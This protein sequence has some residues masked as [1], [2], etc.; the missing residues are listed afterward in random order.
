MPTEY[1]II[2]LFAGP[3][4]LAEGF[5]SI[6]KEDGSQPF[7][8]ALSVEKEASAFDTLR[9]RSFVRQFNGTPPDAYYNFL[10][11]D[12]PEPDWE[13][14]FPIE[15]KSACLETVRLEL[16]S[17]DAT[18]EIDT[19]LAQISQSHGANVILIGGPPCQAYSTSSKQGYQGLRGG[20]GRPPLSIQ[21]IH[22]DSSEGDA[23]C[24]CNGERQ[25]FA[26]VLR[27]WPTRIQSSA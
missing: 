13:E 2:D 4:G 12:I 10:N 5:S 26:L 1:A 24:L 3:G 8:I 7:Q 18:K 15:W 11:G 14:L 17:K 21:G 25:G 22:P 27:R 9:L 16:G 19:R 23:C 20:K 6:R